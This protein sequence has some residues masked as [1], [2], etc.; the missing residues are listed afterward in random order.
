MVKGGVTTTYRYSLG[1]QRYWKQVGTGTPDYYAMDG[2]V[3]AAL[4]T[5]TGTITH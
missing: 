1:G 5:N 3:P 2:S 4:T